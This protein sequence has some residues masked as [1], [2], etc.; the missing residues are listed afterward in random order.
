[1]KILY[2][3]A[4]F[5]FPLMS[6][7]IR[8]Y[9]T[10][11]GL[12]ARHR[13]TLLSLVGRRFQA[14]HV[15]A[16]RPFTERVLTFGTGDTRPPS[17]LHKA[18]SAAQGR[19]P[20]AGMEQSLAEMREA[21]ERCLRVDHFDA[22]F[23]AGKRMPLP[24]GLGTKPLIADLCDATSMGLRKRM[25]H[26]EPLRLPPLILE[27]WSVRRTERELLRLADHLVFA[28][29]RDRDALLRGTHDRA[30]V[31]PN[32]VDLDVWTRRSA[33]R[34]HDAIVITGAMDYAPN[35]DAALVLIREILP[36][37]RKVV[38]SASLWIV[39]RDPRPELIQA[40]RRGGAHVTGMVPDV[41]PYLE[42][43]SVAVAPLRFGA[44]IQNKLLEA[45]AMGVPVVASPLA[46]DGLRTEEGEEPPLAVATT[47]DQ[48]AEQIVEQLKRT[49]LDPRPD[50]DG[51][52]FVERNFTWARSTA[53]L[54]RIL[55]S[56]AGR[57]S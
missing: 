14:E 21:V 35:R 42:Q 51:R 50:A 26:C 27:Y 18:W 11:R 49:K 34:G 37:V 43:A 52:R 41:R 48:F 46:A 36:R 6:G 12:A 40:A 1:M 19:V 22:V 13:L 17:S 2:L 15:D 44:G 33:E 25:R 5:P 7:Y 39:G 24:P 31:V 56:V 28:T 8:H 23:F 53:K 20:F 4:A 47:A 3:T 57:K 32:G 9:F 55:A 54:E 45:M 38:P 10:I 16:L 29:G 30:S